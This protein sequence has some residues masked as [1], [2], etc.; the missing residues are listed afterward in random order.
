MARGRIHRT[1]KR[2]IFITAMGTLTLF[3]GT[4]AASADI[5]VGFCDPTGCDYIVDVPTN[6][7]DCGV[8]FLKNGL[9]KPPTP[10]L[11]TEC[12]T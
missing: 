10:V 5:V 4:P 7:G 6:T 11:V 9:G 3:V 8:V 2:I 12:L 1:M